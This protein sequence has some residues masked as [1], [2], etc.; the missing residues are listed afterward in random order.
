[1]HLSIYFEENKSPNEIPCR[2]TPHG[3]AQDET[4][5]VIWLLS[6]VSDRRECRSLQIRANKMRKPFVFSIP[7]SIVLQKKQNQPQ[8]KTKTFPTGMPKK[9]A[10]PWERFLE[11]VRF[12]EGEPFFS[13]EG[14][15]SPRSFL[16]KVFPLQGLSS[17]RSSSSP[18]R[19]HSTVTDLARLRGRSTSQPSRAAVS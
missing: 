11:G 10:Y 3:F 4:L 17:P 7:P 5:T 16:S 2:L 1:M 18:P 13:E 14:S 12:G 8:K 9:A 6:S 15:P 19:S